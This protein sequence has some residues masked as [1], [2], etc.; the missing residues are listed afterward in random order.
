MEQRKKK[1]APDAAGTS[2]TVL[3]HVPTCMTPSSKLQPRITSSQRVGIRRN[4]GL[5]H[6]TSNFTHLPTK[7]STMPLTRARR[8]GRVAGIQPVKIRR[9]ALWPLI[10][11]FWGARVQA[12]QRP[13]KLSGAGH[14]MGCYPRMQC[15]RCM[16]QTCDAEGKFKYSVCSS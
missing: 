4:K 3:V 6:V 13:A 8:P 14:L 1:I 12:R 5:P 2:E 9:W 15:G 11:G 7:L 10:R 16:L